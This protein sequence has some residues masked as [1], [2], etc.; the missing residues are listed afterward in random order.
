MG[1]G[2]VLPF[3]FFLVLESKQK[4]TVEMSQPLQAAGHQ[5]ILFCP[6]DRNRGESLLKPTR[7]KEVEFY[8]HLRHDPLLAILAPFTPSCRG[9]W[10]LE[11]E[12]LRDDA[13][14][15]P[16]DSQNALLQPQVF[17]GC[18]SSSAEQHKTMEGGW[19]LRLDNLL[20]GME[21]PWVLDVKLGKMRTR[22]LSPKGN[23]KE[24]K[25]AGTPAKSLGV[26]VCG[27]CVS[28]PT[29]I[30]P[31][32]TS[33]P[34]LVSKE[35]CRSLN[36]VGTATLIHNFLH[37]NTCLPPL[38]TASASSASVVEEWL[39]RHPKEVVLGDNDSLVPSIIAAI[40]NTIVEEVGALITLLETNPKLLV[41]YSLVASSLLL[42][43]DRATGRAT[44]KLIDF[45]HSGLR[46]SDTLRD[47]T[48][49]GGTVQEMY[50]GEEKV[51][52]LDSLKNFYK[53]VLV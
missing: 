15:A 12:S 36:E 46:H 44:A 28:F 33:S 6:W 48:D 13:L 29:N 38:A 23:L 14:L 51:C 34:C 31:L 7:L 3:T 5:T 2:K 32:W 24:A 53:M 35:F 52:F 10:R 40:R 4:K 17:S 18:C 26:R 19:I 20:F 45:A 11:K 30:D 41:H 27:V 47:S 49:G 39:V 8:W 9:A 42:V 25:D 16:P 43:A 37:N 1:I 50:Y 21:R 22:P